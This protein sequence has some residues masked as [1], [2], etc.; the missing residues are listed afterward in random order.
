MAVNRE[1]QAGAY[2]ALWS[3]VQLI[4]RGAGIA[5]GGVVRDVALALSGEFRIAYAAVFVI[6]AAGVFGAIWLLRRVDV[7]AFARGAH[8]GAAE[9][10]AAVD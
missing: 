9:V 8:P 1:E 10:L 7:S 6:E 3:V 4:S 2:L 5:A